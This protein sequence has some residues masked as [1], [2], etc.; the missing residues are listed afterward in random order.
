MREYNLHGELSTIDSH[1]KHYEKFMTRSKEIIENLHKSFNSSKIQIH[2]LEI[3]DNSFQFDFFGLDFHV[4]SEI[5][6][7]FEYKVFTIGQLNTYLINE[8][9]LIYIFGYSFDHIGNIENRYILEDFPSF[10]YADFFSKLI[11]YSGKNK[12]KFQFR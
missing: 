8:D 12:I 11:D 9:E 10:Y 7:N 4:K 3:R 1:R 6:F 5:E 2:T